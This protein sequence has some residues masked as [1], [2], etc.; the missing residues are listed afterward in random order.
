ML[1]VGSRSWWIKY[2]KNVAIQS[3][4]HGTF[5]EA[6]EEHARNVRKNGVRKTR[7]MQK[8]K[9]HNSCEICLKSRKP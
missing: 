2:A 1:L 4:K 5:T 6:V 7:R 9:L 8:V 3:M